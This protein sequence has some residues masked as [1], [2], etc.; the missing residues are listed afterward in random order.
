MAASLQ[1]RLEG[2]LHAA[3]SALHAEEQGDL[4]RAWDC[5]TQVHC[6]Q[7]ACLSILASSSRRETQHARNLLSL[8]RFQKLITQGAVL[9]SFTLLQELIPCAHTRRADTP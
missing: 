3:V 8:C 5:Y 7:S 6:V 9:L 1:Q 2:V 4:L